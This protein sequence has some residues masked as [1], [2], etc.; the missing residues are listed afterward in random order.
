MAMTKCK[1]CGAQVSTKADA[2]PQ[3]GA[4]RKTTSLV[5]WIFAIIFGFVLLSGISSLFQDDAPTASSTPASAAKKPAKTAEERKTEWL[6]DAQ[7]MTDALAAMK[8]DQVGSSLDTIKLSL[9]VFDSA[10]RLLQQSTSLSLDD[11]GKQRAAEL[12]KVL[13]RNQAKAFPIM[14]DRMG[15]IFRQEL[16]ISDGSAKTFGNRYTVIEFV[17]ASFAANRNIQAAHDQVHGMLTRLRFKQARY[18]WLSVDD[19][20]TYYKIESPADDVVAIVS[21]TGAVTLVD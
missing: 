18:K 4:K 12:R 11:D 17:N 10:A 2:C 5:T 3:C 9:Q 19:E 15:P 6:N 1:E 14:R 20:Y 8:T 16:W 21:D 13:I 7:V